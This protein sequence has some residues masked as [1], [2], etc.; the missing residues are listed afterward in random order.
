MALTWDFETQGVVNLK[1]RG[2][3]IYA[4]HPST[5]A[6]LASFKLKL[7]GQNEKQK[8]AE[9]AWL[10][11]GGPVNELCRWKRGQPCPPFVRAYIEAGGEFRAHN[12][13]FERLIWWFTLEPLGWPHLPL[14]SCRCTAVAAAAMSLPRD[15]ERLGDALGLKIKKDKRGKALM[16]IHSIPV[17]F[18]TDGEPIWHAKVDDP[19]SLEE[20]HVYCD[21]DVLSEEEADD[22]LIPLSDEECEIYHLNERICDR[23]IRI[24]TASARAA[25]RL[26]GRA[27]VK[28]DAELAAVTGGVVTAVTQVARLKTWCAS[29]G[30][31]LETAGKDDISDALHDF[32]DI[33]DDVRRALELRGEGG[34]TAE[35]KIAGMLRGVGNGDRVYGA[36]L[37]H[38][39]GQ[40]GRFSSRGALQLHNLV[41]YRKIFE[42]AH[43]NLD[44]LFEAIHYEDPDFLKFLYGDELGRPLHLLSDSV[45]SFL[46]AAPNHDLIAVD[47]SAIQGRLS[48]WF[49]GEQ[50]K[51]DAYK[52]LDEGWGPGIY[53]ITASGIW[54]IPVEKVS[55]SLH[56]PGGKVADL[57]LGFRGGVGALSR[58]AR[59]L[60]L[61][62]PPLFPALWEAADAD[63]REHCEDRFKDRLA[64]HD[65]TAERL[66]REGWIAG[67]IIKIGWRKKHPEIEKDWTV[68]ENMAIEA[69]ENPGRVVN[70]GYVKK[71]DMVKPGDGTER[72]ASKISYMTA[73]GFLFAR[74]PSGR[75]LAYGSPKMREVDAP[76]SDKTLPVAEREKVYSLTVRGVEKDHWVRYPLS[77]GP[78]YN[79]GIQGMEY[80]I[81]KVGMKNLEAGG[82]PVVLHCH[83]E[84]TVEVPR[85][86]GDIE[87]VRRL[88]CDMPPWTRGLGISCGGWRG[89]RY[90]KS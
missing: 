14:E 23:G 7:A 42:D 41:K 37:H 82:Y 62:L 66:G 89:K 60:K 48:P 67:E 90:R 33:P 28:I 54:N 8:K 47:Y 72:K 15:L 32:D 88:M 87:E 84:P 55:R 40:T 17:G 86:Y 43:V 6:L 71:A 58:M 9:A 74:L 69:V 21:F 61:K 63:I 85:G 1:T 26:A 3:H 22:R 11:A 73:H 5:S 50:W 2:A 78:Q 52:A 25:L 12:C 38:G 83:D 65:A 31:V 19:E 45:R 34:N 10:A 13:Q 4:K 56:R 64:H 81:L 24:D 18:N 35:S 49:S 30:V 76:W 59:A 44:T 80:D 79:H 57:S 39:A 16:A 51:M 46:W 27:R 36:F 29:R 20:Y 75:C 68:M 53:E 70:S 77:G